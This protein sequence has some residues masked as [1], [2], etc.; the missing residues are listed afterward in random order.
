M[1]PPAPLIIHSY[2]SQLKF[3]LFIT[4]CVFSYS[5][6]AS[7]SIKIM[8]WQTHLCLRSYFYS[9]KPLFE[10]VLSLKNIS[11][12]I[13]SQDNSGF[14]KRHILMVL[15]FWY[16]MDFMD[17]WQW[18]WQGQYGLFK[19]CGPETGWCNVVLN[20]FLSKDPAHSPKTRGLILLLSLTLG[21][22]VFCAWLSWLSVVCVL[23]LNKQDK[24]LKYAECADKIIQQCETVHRIAYH[25]TTTWTWNSFKSF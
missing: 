10:H 18:G 23:F 2:T 22:M 24:T 11:N 8:K 5:A 25:F 21:Q 4:Y 1:R 9:V 13:A 7:V 16:S 17:S 6:V 20:R 19:R 15:I 3:V 14:L 12:L